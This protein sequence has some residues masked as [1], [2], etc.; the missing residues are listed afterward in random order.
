MSSFISNNLIR[1]LA[2][3]YSEINSA[4]LTGAIDVLVIEQPDGTFVSSPFHVRFGKMG[5]LKAKEKIVDIE[6]NEEPADV[7]MKLDDHGAA[8]FVE[9]LS[10]DEEGDFPPELAT[11]PLPGLSIESNPLEDQL[12]GG[13][14]SASTSATDE[15][16]DASK[17]SRSL[18]EEFNKAENSSGFKLPQ[19]PQNSSSRKKRMRK[20]HRRNGSK[21]SL[22]NILDDNRSQREDEVND[23]DLDDEDEQASS[24]QATPT[25]KTFEAAASSANVITS[26]AS[27]SKIQTTPKHLAPPESSFLASRLGSESIEQFL[28]NQDEMVRQHSES[29]VMLQANLAKLKA[30]FKVSGPQ[31]FSEPEMTPAGGSPKGSRP[32]TPVVSS[33]INN[34]ELKA[35]K[36]EDILSDT[37]FE[38][39]RADEEKEDNMSENQEVWN[40]GELPTTISAPAA[41]DHQGQTEAKKEQESKAEEE[42]RQKSWTF[43]FWKSQNEGKGKSNNPGVYL[44]DLKDDDEEMMAIYLGSR[45]SSKARDIPRLNHGSGSNSHRDDDAESG[46]GPSLPMSPHSVEGAI[47]ASAA[48]ENK[49][50]F[51][52]RYE[53]SD[54]EHVK[55]SFNKNLFPSDLA[56]SLCGS[57]EFS[58]SA[59]DLIFEQSLLSYDDFV[60]RLKSPEVHLLDDPALV[61][62]MSGKYYTWANARHMI[63]SYALFNRA[64]PSE[65]VENKDITKT[66]TT[67]TAETVNPPVEPLDLSTTNKELDPSDPA[68]AEKNKSSYIGWLF[69]S[70]KDPKASPASKDGS[71]SPPQQEATSTPIKTEGEKEAENASGEVGQ[72]EAGSQAIDLRTGPETDSDDALGV[73]GKK[74]KKTLRLSSEMIKRLNLQSGSNEAQFSVTTAYQGTTKCRCHI[75]KWKYNDKIVISDIDGTITKSDVLGHVLPIIGRDWAQSGVAKLFTEIDRNG[76]KI[77]YLSARAIGQASVTKDYLESIKQGEC[78]MPDGPLFLNPTSLINAFHREVIERKP[79]KFKIAC[80]RDISKLFPRNP[81]YAGYG[82]RVNDAF[83][84]S[85]V[86]IPTSRIFTINSKGE[87]RH[88]LNQTFQTSYLD[89]SNDVD[90]LYPPVTMIAKLGPHLAK[91]SPQHLLNPLMAQSLPNAKMF[92]FDDEEDEDDGGLKMNMAR[93]VSHN[94]PRRKISAF[95][96]TWSRPFSKEAEDAKDNPD[97]LDDIFQFSNPDT[98]EAKGSPVHETGDKFTTVPDFSYFAKHRQSLVSEDGVEMF[99]DAMS[100]DTSVLRLSELDS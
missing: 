65:F 26:S 79:E 57:A 45:S 64:L 93:S 28:E 33:L 66:E 74:Y 92:N 40:W 14:K 54:D 67:P 10:E 96:D 68:S 69:G 39:E 42:K 87:L 6:I 97:V 22:S 18:I 88:E 82:N 83:A 31:Y 72:T 99:Q 73:K 4:T 11:S 3:W 19:Q 5:V 70:K 25:V 84:Y 50:N 61:V 38:K 47:G 60:M 89:H 77:I 86:G 63:M 71:A 16:D 78:H 9:E 13:K 95:D 81:F 91:M 17:V 30:E 58:A 15:A 1:P 55:S 49:V 76:Y 94:P 46:N 85:K 48:A 36:A 75:Y 27:M 80:L 52:L 29:S 24:E 35:L 34:T 100:R 59:S 53:S 44:D 23:G 32:E 56:F 2:Q 12:D 62:R 90:R 51:N 98:G 8:F 7:H 21:S 43:S 41:K 20:K 37:E